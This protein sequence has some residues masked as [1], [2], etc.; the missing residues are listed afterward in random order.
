MGKASSLGCECVV[1]PLNPTIVWPF[2]AK[3]YF[4]RSSSS[5]KTSWAS[6]TSWKI[7]SDFSLASSPCT[8]SGWWIFANS[9]YDF[10]SKVLKGGGRNREQRGGREEGRTGRQDLHREVYISKKANGEDK[11]IWGGGIPQEIKRFLI[12]Q[13][14]CFEKIQKPKATTDEQGWRMQRLATGKYTRHSISGAQ[15]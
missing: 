9:R 4:A 14:R 10:A 11:R 3:T 7:F 2:I 13:G 1:Y 6:A 5:D 12:D 8:L 15:I